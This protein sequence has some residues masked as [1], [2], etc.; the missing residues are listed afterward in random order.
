MYVHQV[1][2]AWCRRR[3]EEVVG[4]PGTR[5]IG[6]CKPSDVGAGN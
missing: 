5:A 1:L 4:G 6:N 2:R 3:P